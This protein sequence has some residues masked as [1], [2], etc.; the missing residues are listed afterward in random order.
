MNFGSSNALIFAKCWVAGQLA[1]IRML[2][3]ELSEA[4]KKSGPRNQASLRQRVSELNEWVN[5]VDRA[6]SVRQ[7]RDHAPAA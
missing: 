6:L 1:G 2:E 7:Y 4:F 3:Q 5:L